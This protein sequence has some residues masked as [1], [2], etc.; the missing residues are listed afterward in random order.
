MAHLQ[1]GNTALELAKKQNKAECVALLEAAMNKA[2]EEACASVTESTPAVEE[3]L[4]FWAKMGDEARLTALLER[5]IANI[6]AKDKVGEWMG[7][8]V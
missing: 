2:H 4:L 8:W 7:G 6:E 1:G 3:A 5:G